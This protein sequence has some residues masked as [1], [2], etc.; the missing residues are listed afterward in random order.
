S[1]CSGRAGTGRSFSA[2][3]RRPTALLKESPMP[4]D[5]M[6]VA[7]DGTGPGPTAATRGIRMDPRLIGLN[8]ALLLVLG[9]VSWSNGQT[10]GTQP[11]ATAPHAGRAGGEYAFVGGKVQGMQGN[12]HAVYILDA[13]NR[14]VAAIRWD[15]SRKIF[16]AIGLRRLADDA[17]YM[18]PAR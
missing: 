8:L 4:D 3:H 16:E 6:T 9:A 2:H 18:Q 14:E 15:R 5:P 1:A 13:A 11:G 10:S 12:G 17:H 7:T